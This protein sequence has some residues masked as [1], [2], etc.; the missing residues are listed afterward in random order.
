MIWYG[1]DP[2]P[3]QLYRL[4]RG[5]WGGILCMAVGLGCLEYVLEEGQR[6]DWFGDETI[7]VCAL[8]AGIFLTAFLVIAFTHREPFLDL[9]L[10]GR[11]SLGA[12]TAMNLGDRPR[13]VRDR[14]HHAALSDAGAGL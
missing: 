4:K 11:K 9:R 2:A 12:A 8:L 6:K 3:A 7:R 13:A 5:D 14:L 10:L 1:L